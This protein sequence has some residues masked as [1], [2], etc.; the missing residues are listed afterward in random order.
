[1]N[2]ILT[3]TLII[4]SL[5][6]VICTFA[7]A[8][9]DARTFSN[10]ITVAVMTEYTN[11]KP[12][13][14]IID[15]VYETGSKENDTIHKIFVSSKTKQFFGYDLE[16]LPSSE[17]GKFQVT[18]KPLSVKP[19]PEFVADAKN[20]TLRTLPKYPETMVVNDGDT[21]LLDILE[22]P[23][24]KEKV[25][26]V[27]KIINHW[28]GFGSLFPERLPVTPPED[29]RLEDVEL[30]LKKF[31]VF[32]ND[33]S[34]TKVGGG[35]TGSLV[36]FYFPNGKNKGRFIFSLI[37]RKDYNFQKIGTLQD[38]R[39][40]F[41]FNGEK[42][43]FV[44]E[45]PIVGTGKIWNVWVLYD[46]DYKPIMSKDGKNFETGAADDAKYLFRNNPLLIFS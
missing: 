39:L 37:P 44:T 41:T 11:S 45:L 29:F 43:K 31:E 3:K 2:K 30:R 9:G 27:I 15:R 1:M 20:L 13:T 21:I 6:F 22:N 35:A 32:V 33:E 7:K 19:N 28:K 10:G 46:P 25:T 5:I 18:I 23:Q 4:F 16:V 12:S 34:V 24:T 17:K 38:E 40:E 8:Q 42:Y 26:E 14:K 36:S